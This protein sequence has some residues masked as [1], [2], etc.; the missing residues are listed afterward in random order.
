M[1]PVNV[2]D[3]QM[4]QKEYPHFESRGGF[5]VSRQK[6]HFIPHGSLAP[7]APFAV[8]ASGFPGS[9]LP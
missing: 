8:R 2:R 5:S 1:E 9:F 7:A 3:E 4:I 6:S